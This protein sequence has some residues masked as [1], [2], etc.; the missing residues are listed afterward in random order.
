[1]GNVTPNGGKYLGPL[2]STSS[3]R[4]VQFKESKS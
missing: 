1:M 3:G 2:S 4:M